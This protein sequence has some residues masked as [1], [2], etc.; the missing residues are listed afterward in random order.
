MPNRDLNN[1]RES[2]ES[3]C[4]L[5]KDCDKNPF[6][7]FDKWFQQALSEKIK[8]PN[9]MQIATVG[10]DGQPSI[11]T[12]LLKSFD[13]DGFVF[14][15][16]YKSKKGIQLAQNNKIAILFFYEE[17]ERQI[18]IEGIVHKCTSEENN[19]YFHAR[20]VDSQIAATIS[21]QSQVVADRAVLENLFEAKKQEFL[22]KEIPL[23]EDWGGYIVTPVLFEF[24]QGRK[25]RLHD[26]IQYTKTKT[27]DWIMERLMP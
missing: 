25:N 4:L 7:Q 21:A 1:M 5:E 12:V 20:P 26:R 11:R 9:A 2:Y 18:R 10:N 14:Y 22:N 16:N 19:A 24:W 15:T 13:K 23:K 3:G 17:H 8:E 6:N 27:G